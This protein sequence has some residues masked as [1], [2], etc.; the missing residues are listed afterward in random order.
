MR[1]L[2]VAVIAFGAARAHAEPLPPGSLQFASGIQGGAGV[3]AKR[4]GFGYQ[5][6]AQAAWQPMQ[7]QQRVGW[8]VRWSTM[9]GASYDADAA[10][11][12]TLRTVAGELTIGARIKPGARPGRYITVRGGFELFRSN[13]VIAPQN[14]RDFAGPVANVGYELYLKNTFLLSADV[15]YGMIANGP[16]QVAI[17]FAFGVVGP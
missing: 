4:L 2:V 15:H 12:D 1:W 7:T 5:V 13:Q 10:R 9:F 16:E 3:D 17:V 11:I 6:G 8:A 14:V